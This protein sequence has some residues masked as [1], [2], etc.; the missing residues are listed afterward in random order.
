MRDVYSAVADP[1]R[2]RLIDMLAAAD[3][4][5][6]HE[7][8]APFSL[9]RTAVSKHL[10]VL[11][12]AGL[13]VDRK[14]GRETLYRLTPGPLRELQDWVSSYER[15]WTERLGNLKSLLQEEDQ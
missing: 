14:A 13:V 9:G 8:T 10:A 11:N 3:E 6:L 7:L 12:E 15:F 2:R 5:P 4:L 1:T